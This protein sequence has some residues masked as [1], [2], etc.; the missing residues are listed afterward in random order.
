M[1]EMTD[2]DD[3]EFQ[4]SNFAPPAE[5]ADSEPV[6]IKPRT[7]LNINSNDNTEQDP[8]PLI[9]IKVAM[10]NRNTIIYT[11]RKKDKLKSLMENYCKKQALDIKLIRFITETGDRAKVYLTPEDLDIEDGETITIFQRQQAGR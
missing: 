9:K 1:S 6:D 3:W 7:N 8:N 4:A 11:V 10:P 5:F 2:N